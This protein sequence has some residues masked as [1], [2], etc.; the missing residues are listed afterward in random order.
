[1]DITN[2]HF[3]QKYIWLAPLWEYIDKGY[4]LNAIMVKVYA[5]DA[6]RHVVHSYIRDL[7]Q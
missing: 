4:F 5:Y 1:M 7:K 2:I 6:V 3:T